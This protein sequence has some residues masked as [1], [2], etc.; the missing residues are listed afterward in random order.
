VPTSPA[1]PPRPAEFVGCSPSLSGA[2]RVNPWSI[3]SVADGIYAAIKMPQEHQQLRHEKHWRYV[4][5][6]TVS[7]W[8]QSYVTD[9]QVG[10]AGLRWAE[11]GCAGRLGGWGVGGGD[12]AA[13]RRCNAA[14][15]A[16]G[17]RFWRPGAVPQ[18][19]RC[20]CP[21]ACQAPVTRHAS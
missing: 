21:A 14:A 2:I 11:L 10:S 17:E 9:L 20:G 13:V 18:Q 1:A 15:F 7:Y 3:E 6:H 8:A 12:A 16:A 5:Q 19:Q 4:S